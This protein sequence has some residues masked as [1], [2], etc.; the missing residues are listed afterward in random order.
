MDLLYLLFAIFCIHVILLRRKSVL[1]QVVHVIIINL[2]FNS[3]H[4]DAGSNKLLLKN[5]FIQHCD[6]TVIISM[7]FI[8]DFRNCQSGGNNGRFP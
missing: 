1:H 5:Q 6:V 4:D 7:R 8:N 2:F 3:F